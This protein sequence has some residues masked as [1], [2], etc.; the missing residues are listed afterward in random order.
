[1]ICIESSERKFILVTTDFVH[2]I[3][4]ETVKVQYFL[5][6]G[7]LQ[8]LPWNLYQLIS[9]FFAFIIY[10]I[11]IYKKNTRKPLQPEMLYTYCQGQ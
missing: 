11:N 5:K 8:V 1:L 10:S 9:Y 3:S 7:T 2:Y 4:V 6:L